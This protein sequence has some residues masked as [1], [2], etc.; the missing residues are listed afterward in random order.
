MIDNFYIRNLLDSQDIE[1][2]KYL[3]N[4]SDNEWV[5]GLSSVTFEN[6]KSEK[7]MKKTKNNLELIGKKE[8]LNEINNIIFSKLD[9]DVKFLTFT[10]ANESTNPIISKT[11]CGSYYKPHH[12]SSKNGHYSTT[13]FLNDPD[14]Y[15]G[16]ELVLLTD[17]NPKKIKLKS[18]YAITYKTGILHEVLEVKSGSRYAAVFWTTSKIKNSTIRKYWTSISQACSL[19]KNDYSTNSVEECQNNPIFILENLKNEIERDFH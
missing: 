18:G 7:D 12:D 2:I 5:D 19:I 10:C 11:N 4:K 8:T 16:G 14:E 13:I 17:G 9:F 1:E 3:V 6:E 15:E